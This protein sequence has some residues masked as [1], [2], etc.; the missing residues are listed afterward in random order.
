ME[1]TGPS[2]AAR[3]A[4]E[5]ARNDERHSGGSS[6]WGPGSNGWLGTRRSMLKPTAH[7][8]LTVVCSQRELIMLFRLGVQV[9]EILNELFL[10]IDW[11]LEDRCFGRRTEDEIE[12]GCSLLA[13]INQDWLRPSD[14]K[15]ALPCHHNMNF[16]TF[17][18]FNDIA[19]IEIAIWKASLENDPLASKLLTPLIAKERSWTKS[20]RPWV[21]TTQEWKCLMNV[22]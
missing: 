11:N 3:L 14:S 4:G 12:L 10:D 2:L 18:E 7:W 20:I 19:H 5:G 16:E 13:N 17:E 6:G 15:E 8:S 1:L 22:K 21:R 9:K